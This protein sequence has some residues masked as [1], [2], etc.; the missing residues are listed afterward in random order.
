[1][2]RLNLVRSGLNT[3]ITVVTHRPSPR[4]MQQQS[5]SH[6]YSDQQK[7]FLFHVAFFAGANKVK[8]PASGQKNAS[9]IGP[10]QSEYGDYRIR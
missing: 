1:V 10:L 4:L 3:G 9:E 2:F 7:Q 6:Q 8:A 5:N